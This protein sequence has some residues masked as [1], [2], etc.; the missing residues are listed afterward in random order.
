MAKKNS[1]KDIEFINGWKQALNP[2]VVTLKN[3]VIIPVSHYLAPGLVAKEAFSCHT[4]L[5]D[6]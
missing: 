4:D 3:L 5:T 1:P 2:G 6:R